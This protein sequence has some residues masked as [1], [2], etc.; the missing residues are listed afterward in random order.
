MRTIIKAR[1]EGVL[2][3]ARHYDWLNLKEQTA[4]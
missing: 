1:I 4:N 3:A 2:A